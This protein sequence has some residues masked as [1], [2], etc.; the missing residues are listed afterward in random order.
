MDLPIL[1]I[2][3]ES[4]NV[5]IISFCLA[6]ETYI[7]SVL[8]AWGTYVIFAITSF[9]LTFKDTVDSVMRR[10]SIR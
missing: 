4:R 1:L 3:E 6:W 7:M 5:F 10:I 2:P 9:V 8:L